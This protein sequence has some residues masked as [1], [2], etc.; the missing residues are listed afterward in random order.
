MM[1]DAIALQKALNSMLTKQ[2]PLSDTIVSGKPNLLN[3]V[4]SYSITAFELTVGMQNASI[5]LE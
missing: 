1:A 4:L 3:S 2:V 5:H